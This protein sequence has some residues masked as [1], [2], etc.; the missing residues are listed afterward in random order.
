LN[1]RY[2]GK[3]DQFHGLADW[4]YE[5]LIQTGIGIVSCPVPQ[6][7]IPN[8]VAAPGPLGTFPLPDDTY[9]VTTSW[10]NAQG[11]EGACAVAAAVKTAFSTLLVQAG[12]APRNGSAWNVYVGASPETMSL[13]N[14]SP[15]APGQTWLQ[16]GTLNKTGRAPGTGQS[17]S[18]IQPVPRLL[19][20][21]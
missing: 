9:F 19:Q 13:Q 3:R 6:P 11:E 12:R 14:T 1:D 2:A 16:P 8:V 7:A 10:L 5:K 21:G 18:F 20:R 15:L 4:A 17:P